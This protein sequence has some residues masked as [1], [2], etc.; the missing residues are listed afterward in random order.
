MA[1][2]TEKAI[3]DPKRKFG[4][5]KKHVQYC[6]SELTM[7][8]GESLFDKGVGFSN[9]SAITPDADNE[10]SSHYQYKLIDI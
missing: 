8:I 9:Y 1:P 7:L 4:I 10:K 2:W 6:W 5:W 3:T